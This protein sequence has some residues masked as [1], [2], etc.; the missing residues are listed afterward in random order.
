[1]LFLNH[2]EKNSEPP[3]LVT[4]VVKFKQVKEKKSK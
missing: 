2:Q 4:P 1:M 3:K